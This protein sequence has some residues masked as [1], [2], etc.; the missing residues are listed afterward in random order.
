M[1]PVLALFFHSG[2]ASLCRYNKWVRHASVATVSQ[3][4]RAERKLLRRAS[5]VWAILG[6]ARTILRHIA[7][8][9]Q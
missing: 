7:K 1:S 9:R 3:W 6:I 8:N 4:M 2:A 5:R